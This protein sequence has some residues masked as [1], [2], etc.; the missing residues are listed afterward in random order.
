MT[1]NQRAFT[2][3]TAGEWVLPVPVKRKTKPKAKTKR[4]AQR[5]SRKANR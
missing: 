5:D 4:K 1:I 2:G 3:G